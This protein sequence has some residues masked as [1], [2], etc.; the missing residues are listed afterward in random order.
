MNLRVNTSPAVGSNPSGVGTGVI[1]PSFS[2][3]NSYFF[4]NQV[5]ASSVKSTDFNVFTVSYIVNISGDQQPGI[6]TTT[7]TYVAVAAF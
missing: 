7:L 5:V 4:N 2:V 1:S 6:Y 3:P